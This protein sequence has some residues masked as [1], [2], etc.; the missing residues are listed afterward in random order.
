MREL[1]DLC[2]AVKNLTVLTGNAL[3]TLGDLLAM[4]GHPGPQSHN[5]F[6]QLLG[7]QICQGF[8]GDTMHAS[9]PALTPSRYWHQRM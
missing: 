5:H 1:I 7:V 6:T 9:V 3:V 2:L 4:F 8:K